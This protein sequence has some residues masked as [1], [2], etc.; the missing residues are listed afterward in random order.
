MHGLRS[1]APRRLSF[2]FAK[3][4][5]SRRARGAPGA[6][7][8]LIPGRGVLGSLP[9]RPASFRG[10]RRSA[11][12]DVVV[13]GCDGV[14]DVQLCRSIRPTPRAEPRSQARLRHDR[15]GWILR[16][17]SCGL[18]S[19]TQRVLQW[20]RPL[21]GYYFDRDGSG[22]CPGGAAPEHLSALT[23][24]RRGPH[25]VDREAWGLAGV[26]K[27]SSGSKGRV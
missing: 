20:H 21:G 18:D 19:G 13:L 15:S 22:R 4:S 6:G 3:P 7:L 26:L 2:A 1:V 10:V 5:R 17:R 11:A 23:I 16:R 27:T 14:F 8:R 25:T 24:P 9:R 12:A